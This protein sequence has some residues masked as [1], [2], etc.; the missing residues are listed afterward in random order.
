M[1]KKKPFIILVIVVV[2]LAVF[3]LR[4]AKFYPFLFQFIFNH[5][6]E[7]KKSDDNINIL[8]LGIG[9]G[10]HD[11]PN[12]SDSMIF[13]SINLNKNKVTL[14]SIPR[15]L[16]ISDINQKINAAYAIGQ[17]K[18][19]G[20]GLVLAEAVVSKVVGQPVDYGVRIDFSGFVKAVDEVGGL[21]ITV[22]RSFIDYK[23]PIEGK[24]DDSC[25]HTVEELKALA[26]ASSQ[27][28]AF[29]CRYMTVSFN[30]GLQHMDGKTALEFVRSR[31]ALGQEGTDFARS[32]RQEKVIKAFKDKI[33]SPQT[34]LD[35]GKIL[36]LYN[37][38]KN[39]IDTDIKSDEFDDFIRLGEK[40]KNAKIQTTVIDIGDE[41]T[42][43]PGLLVN[44]PISEATD[45]E[46]ILVPRVGN[47]N[48]S[49]IHKYVA[50]EIKT[51]DCKVPREPAK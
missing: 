5:N 40:M 47:G 45:Y 12:L 24:E 11:G 36:N 50:C 3:I 42:K 6:I 14:I 32:Q 43:R 15:D 38:V 21:D 16:W 41:E 8:L 39:S 20:G 18:R 28:Q 31:H 26:T 44:P 22:D 7:L 33:I 35:P 2:V 29:P 46:W 48:F 23:Y 1:R 9:G 10:N 27:L 17:E 37:I 51:G 19:A 30:K 25:G 4:T 34:L 49:E 13:A